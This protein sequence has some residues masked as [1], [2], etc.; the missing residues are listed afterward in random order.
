M[1]LTLVK[2]FAD[3]STDFHVFRYTQTPE[4][5]ADNKCSECGSV[6]SLWICLICGYVGCGRYVQGHAYTHFQ[7]EVELFL[8]RG[9]L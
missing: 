3:I 8:Q 5:V 1:T 7:V 4:A 2:C 6:E 9:A